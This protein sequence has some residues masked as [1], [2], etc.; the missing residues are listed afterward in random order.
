MGT[1]QHLQRKPPIS[2]TPAPTASSLWVHLD[3]LLPS[4]HPFLSKLIPSRRHN[5]SIQHILGIP[6]SIS[7]FS[8][9]RG[10]TRPAFLML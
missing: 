2:S 7:R 9:L 5:V 1:F 6:L 4:P 10:K 3:R 8:L